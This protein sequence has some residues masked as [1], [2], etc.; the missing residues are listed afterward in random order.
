MKRRSTVSRPDH[1]SNAGGIGG[2]RQLTANA[3]DYLGCGI[4][5]VL[6]LPDPHDCPTCVREAMIGI[7]VAP[8]V[9]PEL[10]NP[11]SMV[12]SGMSPVLRASVPE[13]SI[14]Q[15]SYLRSR[16][17]DVCAPPNTGDRQ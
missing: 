4:P 13:A 12:G 7:S 3:G 9:A 11:P 15:D 1:L 8:P 2:S 10:L 17:E 16:E 6:V 5:W 14:H